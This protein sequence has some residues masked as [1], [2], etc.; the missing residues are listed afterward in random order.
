MKARIEA[1]KL[2]LQTLVYLA[3][4]ALIASLFFKPEFTAKRTGDFFKA[5]QDHDINIKIA[6]MGFNISPRE[7]KELTEQSSV[8]DQAKLSGAC[9]ARGRCSDEEQ[10]QLASIL[11]IEQVSLYLEKAAE[12]DVDPSS[13]SPPTASNEQGVL[14]S[15]IMVPEP[16]PVG[17][18]DWVVVL[19]AD[20]SL[21]AA[22]DEQRQIAARLDRIEIDLILRDN[23]YRTV[24]FF[25]T[26]AQAEAALPTLE[27]AARRKGIYARATTIWC[28]GAVVT[29][30]DGIIA[31]G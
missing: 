3:L 25:E 26:A 19:G 9:L 13:S 15:A 27:Q 5:F 4:L 22:R 10:T 11:Q 16:A 31:C 14:E 21:D 23:W 24:A 30:Q 6:A 17:V 18:G 20:R 12:P 29:G 1:I 28:E 2:A 7:V 8:L